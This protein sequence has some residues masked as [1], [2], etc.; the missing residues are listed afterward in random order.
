MPAAVSRNNHSASATTN[1]E[2]PNRKREAGI[3]VPPSALSPA[4]TAIRNGRNRGPARNASLRTTRAGRRSSKP[5]GQSALF[6]VI[7]LE[8]H[9]DLGFGC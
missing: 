8:S 5:Q 6:E 1:S 9:P 2:R 3:P 4:I 7:A